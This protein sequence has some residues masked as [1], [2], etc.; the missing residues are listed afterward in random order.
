VAFRYC[1]TPKHRINTFEP[2]P[3]PPDANRTDMRATMLGNTMAGNLLHLTG[4]DFIR[5]VWE[6]GQGLRTLSWNL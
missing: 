4:W 5:Q 1:V 2:K 6:A 3:T